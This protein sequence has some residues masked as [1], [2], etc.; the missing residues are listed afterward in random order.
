[1]SLA[2]F[3]HRLRRLTDAQLF[4]LSRPGDADDRI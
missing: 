3:R 4:A 2:A 1:M